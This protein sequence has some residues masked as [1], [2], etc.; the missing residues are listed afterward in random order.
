MIAP[1]MSQVSGLCGI[2]TQGLHSGGSRSVTFN[3]ITAGKEMDAPLS[4]HTDKY[5]KVYMLIVQLWAEGFE[6]PLKSS[7][8]IDFST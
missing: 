4:P 7:S 5:S 3:M 2:V 8:R 6:V 1:V